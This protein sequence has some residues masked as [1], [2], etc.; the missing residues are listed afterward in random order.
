MEVIKLKQRLAQSCCY[1]TEISTIKHILERNPGLD[2]N[3]PCSLTDPRAPVIS[4][5]FTYYTYLQL[6][7]MN[8]NIEAVTELLKVNGIDVNKVTK[9]CKEPPLSL[10]LI[11]HTDSNVPIVEKL[12]ERNEL[13]VTVRT[14]SGTWVIYKLYVFAQVFTVKWNP[15]FQRCLKRVTFSRLHY[16]RGL[17][18]TIMEFHRF[19]QRIRV[20]IVLASVHT[21]VGRRSLLRLIKPDLLEYVLVPFLTNNFY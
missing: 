12:L 9:T 6:A 8:G 7:C 19:V 4:G 5:S 2:I 14:A 21:R 17:G 18:G 13:D 1:H 3:E 15:T 16:T 20:Y 10:A 11:S